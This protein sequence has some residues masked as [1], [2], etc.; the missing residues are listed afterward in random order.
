MD[1]DKY[2]SSLSICFQKNVPSQGTILTQKKKNFRTSYIFEIFWDKYE[3]RNSWKEDRGIVKNKITNFIPS[4][5]SK[6]GNPLHLFVIIQHVGRTVWSI[7]C[8]IE[9][10][11][12]W[13]CTEGNLASICRPTVNESQKLMKLFAQNGWFCFRGCNPR[14]LQ[15][16]TCVAL[17]PLAYCMKY[18]FKIHAF[19]SQFVSP[20]R[21]YINEPLSALPRLFI[22]FISHPTR[23]IRDF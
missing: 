4:K 16:F 3:F 13:A 19:R 2:Y 23:H 22:E 10:R 12:N 17:Y 1:S 6:F 5:S 11:R 7:F 18:R 8:N 15:C 9:S 20:V 21:G 14:A